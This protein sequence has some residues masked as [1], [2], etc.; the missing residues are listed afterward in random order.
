M[1]KFAFL[2]V[3]FLDIPV[4]FSNSNAIEIYLQANN[5]Y[6]SGDFKKAY[7]LYKTVDNPGAMLNY[8]LGN[9]AY[10]LGLYA[11]SMLY[12]KRAEIGSGIFGRYDILRNIEMLKAILNNRKF[13]LNRLVDKFRFYKS[14]CF[15]I[16]QS[17]PL[18]AFQI[19]FLF[20]WFFMFLLLRY[21]LRKKL[22]FFV[23]VIAL[24]GIFSAGLLMLRYHLDLSNYAIII[25][26][27]DVLSGPSSKFQKLAKLHSASIVRRVLSIDNYVK[28]KIKSLIGLIY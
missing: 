1:I 2:I 6:R 20:L 7:E 15:S 27:V 22:K 9:A 19:T 16:I 10:K 18:L 24:V 4:A 12:W 11:E 14:Y 8:N 5:W 21:F 26:D 3:M 17:A 28:I 25:N 23:F 13:D